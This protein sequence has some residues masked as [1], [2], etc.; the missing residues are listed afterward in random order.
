MATSSTDLKP[1]VRTK[2]AISGLS[3]V[4]FAAALAALLVPLYLA[5]AGAPLTG[6]PGADAGFCALATCVFFL[7]SFALMNV[8]IFPKQ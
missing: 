8:D 7:A 3:L 6:N 4:P 2:L 1:S 5:S